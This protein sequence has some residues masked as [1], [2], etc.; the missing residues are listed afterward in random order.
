MPRQSLDESRF[1]SLASACLQRVQT[2]LEE[3]DPDELDYRAADGLIKL[4]FPDGQVFVL[5][6][7][8][9][10]HQMWLAAGVRAWHYDWHGQDWRDDRD[11]HELFS[12]LSR[13]VSEKLG[14]AVQVG[15][16]PHS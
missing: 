16:A 15:T 2:W 6:R 3:F 9:G 12:N 10:N 7:Q 14:R 8:G 1:S 11:G 5:N 4:E 13:V